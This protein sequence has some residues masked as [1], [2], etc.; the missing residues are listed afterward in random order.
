MKIILIYLLAGKGGSPD[1]APGAWRARGP[2]WTQMLHCQYKVVIHNLRYIKFC[3]EYDSDQIHDINN[4]RMDIKER[5]NY[6]DHWQH[7]A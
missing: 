7:R 1:P 5:R 6:R 2:G 4:L 3:L